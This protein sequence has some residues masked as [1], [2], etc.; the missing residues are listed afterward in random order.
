MCT[1]F[2]VYL[3]MQHK[4]VYLFGIPFSSLMFVCFFPDEIATVFRTGEKPASMYQ[5]LL[6]K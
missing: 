5:Q 6:C 4:I 2:G 3:Y 1:Q